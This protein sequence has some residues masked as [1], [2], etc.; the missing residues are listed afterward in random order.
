MRSVERYTQLVGLMKG[1][2]LAER[3][4]IKPLKLSLTLRM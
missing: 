4:A 3:G 2:V 1:G